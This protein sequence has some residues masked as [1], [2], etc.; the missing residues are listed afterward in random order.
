SDSRRRKRRDAPPPRGPRRDD[1]GHRS[2]FGRS[3]NSYSRKRQ[4]EPYTLDFWPVQR[5]LRLS[6]FGRLPTASTH[7]P[8]PSLDSAPKDTGHGFCPRAPTEPPTASYV[9]QPHP[10]TC[11]SSAA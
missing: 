3:L 9:Q 8:S 1:A 7:P 4:S 5:V 11:T 6:V 2:H 10:E